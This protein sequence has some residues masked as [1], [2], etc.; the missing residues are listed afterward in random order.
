MAARA[1]INIYGELDIKCEN[2]SKVVKMGDLPSHEEKCGRT[3]CYNSD[4][5]DG[6]ENKKIIASKPVCS[7]KC[8]LLLDLM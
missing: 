6:Y 1:L 2:C 4:V 8:K 7:D 5:C 3:G